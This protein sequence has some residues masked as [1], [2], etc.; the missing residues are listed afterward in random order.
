MSARVRSESQHG[1]VQRR[2]VLRRIKGGWYVYRKFYEGAREHAKPI[3]RHEYRGK[4][5]RT[6]TTRPTYAEMEF[7]E[8]LYLADQTP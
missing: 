2:L 4:F 5:P 6:R 8:A 3:Y 1:G 7:L